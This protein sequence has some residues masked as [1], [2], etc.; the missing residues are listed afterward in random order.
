MRRALFCLILAYITLPVPAQPLFEMRGVWFMTSVGDGGWPERGPGDTP[1]RQAEALRARIREAHEA[2]MNTFIFQAVSGGTALY[3]SA[4]LPWSALPA[5]PGL[6][7]G[8]D[9]L[10][11]AVDEAH[12]LGMTLHAWVDVLVVGEAATAATYTGTA[13]AHVLNQHPDWIREGESLRWLDPALPAVRDWLREVVRE[14]VTTHDV[15]AV[16]LD[17]LRY[18]SGGF[19]EDALTYALD[20]R[21]FTAIDDWRRDNVTGLLRDLHEALLTERPAL[22][23]GA[24]PIGNVIWFP[25]AWPALWGFSDVFQDSHRWLAEGLLDYVVPQLYWDFGTAPEPG[26]SLASPD[27]GYLLDDWLAASS[28]T[29]VAPGLAAFKPYLAPVLPAQVEAARNAGADGAVFFR[30]DHL[31]AFDPVSLFPAPA[32][33]LPLTRRH[34]GAIP[35]APV[36]T[37]TALD[38]DAGVLL[39][40]TPAP[41]DEA[42]PLARYV[43]FRD[44]GRPPGRTPNAIA[45]VLPAGVTSWVDPAPPGGTVHYN[46]VAQSRR[47]LTSAAGLSATV[48]VAT[49]LAASPDLPDRP[50]LKALYPNPTRD[51]LTLEYALPHSGPIRVSV[52]DALGRTVLATTRMLPAGEGHLRLGLPGRPPGLYALVFSAE[53]TRQAQPFLLVR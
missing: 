27:F 51:H 39:S 18:P 34:P 15:D 36:P 32:L 16:H 45:A 47:G 12:R 24:A 37:A 40:W 21:G 49:A 23:L 31:D 5:G 41:G 30:F 53:G 52:V 4:L 1:E 42:D 22:T 43:V 2:G 33:P 3:P 11:V 13:P 25:G 50:A 17:W 7:P 10:A 48:T 14:L 35:P 46:V 29:P 38:G 44:T 20:P 28:G 6:D 8:Y 9:P 26:D 19:P